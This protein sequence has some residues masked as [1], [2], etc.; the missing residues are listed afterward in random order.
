MVVLTVS[1]KIGYCIQTWNLI[2]NNLDIYGTSNYPHK[3]NL[4]IIRRTFKMDIEITFTIFCSLSKK[5]QNAKIRHQN[6]SFFGNR[7]E[8]IIFLPGLKW[9]ASNWNKKQEGVA[10]A[11]SQTQIGTLSKKNPPRQ[12][13]RRDSAKKLMVFR[14]GGWSRFTLRLLN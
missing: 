11:A 9:H 7:T 12:D 1:L 5:T 10:V 14:D 13:R 6:S 4:T 2:F 3:N 8:K